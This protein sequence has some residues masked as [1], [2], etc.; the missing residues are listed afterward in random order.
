MSS[1]HLFRIYSDGWLAGPRHWRSYFLFGGS[2]RGD[3]LRG[4][5][6]ILAVAFWVGWR[7]ACA[8]QGGWVFQIQNAWLA[9]HPRKRS[10]GGSTAPAVD[11]ELEPSGIRQW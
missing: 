8:P 6:L 9:E 1:R 2:S 10:D 3:R 7:N 5:D 4:N 11:G